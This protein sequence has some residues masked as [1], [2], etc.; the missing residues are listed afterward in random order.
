MALLCVLLG[1]VALYVG[2]ARSYFTAVG[3][4]KEKHAEVRRLEDEHER[5]KARRKALMEPA[6]LER[7]A[8]RLGYVKPGEKAY[9][10]E[11]LPDSP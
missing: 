4:A 1:I 11:D 7:E 9:V 2:P 5:L 3:E 10:I 8:R 6:T